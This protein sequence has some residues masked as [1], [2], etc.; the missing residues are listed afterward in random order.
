MPSHQETK[1]TLHDL[2]ANDVNALVNN[3]QAVLIDVREPAEF[4]AERIPGALLFPLSEFDP[5]NLPLDTQKRLVLQ[6]GS[7][8]RSA[9]AAQRLFAAGIG[10][11]WHLAGGIKAWKEAHLPVIAFDPAT[12]KPRMTGA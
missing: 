7:G 3:H 10:E 6:C 2:T 9:Q 1:H 12:G 11:T 8:K 4:D 5:A